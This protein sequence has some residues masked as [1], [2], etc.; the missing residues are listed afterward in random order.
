MLLNHLDDIILRLHHRRRGGR[1]PLLHHYRLPSAP[2]GRPTPLHLDDLAAS[3]GVA[4]ARGAMLADYLLL[5]YF[6]AAAEAE[7][8]VD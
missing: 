5:D 8:G 7:A 1:S 4:P 6:C 2:W 3:A